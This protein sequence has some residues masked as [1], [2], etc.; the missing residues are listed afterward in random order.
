MGY[1]AAGVNPPPYPGLA[2]SQPTMYPPAALEK[3]AY[4]TQ[5]AYNPN[6]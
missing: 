5:P 4:Q 6:Y 1:P 2:E 3:A